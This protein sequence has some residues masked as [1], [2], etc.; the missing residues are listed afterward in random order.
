MCILLPLVISIIIIL[1]Y[2]QFNGKRSEWNDTDKVLHEHMLTQPV[3]IFLWNWNEY[4][5]ILGYTVIVF[6]HYNW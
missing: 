4:I 2:I 1:T 5:S 6:L 3:Y